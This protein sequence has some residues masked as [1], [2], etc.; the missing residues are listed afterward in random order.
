M[1]L[2][3]ADK[4]NFIEDGLTGIVGLTDVENQI[5]LNR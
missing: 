5:Q 4:T 1:D 3:F 2:N